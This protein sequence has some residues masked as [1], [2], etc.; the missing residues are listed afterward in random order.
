MDP[1]DPDIL[2]ERR[3]LELKAKLDES[4]SNRIKVKIGNGDSSILTRP[5]N[6]LILQEIINDCGN[7]KEEFSTH[8]RFT[9][10]SI[11]CRLSLRALGIRE[12]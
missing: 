9:E 8:P 5:K 2:A 1:V 10:L 7:N 4:R 12:N 3:R 11:E 6:A